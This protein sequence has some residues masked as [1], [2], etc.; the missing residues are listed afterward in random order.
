MKIRWIFDFLFNILIKLC[1]FLMMK[2]RW[3][4]HENLSPSLSGVKVNFVHNEKCWI[5]FSTWLR[6]SRRGTEGEK[7]ENLTPLSTWP[8]RSIYGS[9]S[10]CTRRSP[11]GISRWL[12]KVFS[13]CIW[14][15]I[16]DTWLDRVGYSTASPQGILSVFRGGPRKEILLEMPGNHFRDLNFVSRFNFH[17]EVAW[18]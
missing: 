6:G 13:F 12:L 17:R 10:Q 18:E 2:C 4:Q 14:S 11:S 7:S 16:M 9:V 3:C 8:L 1:L 5:E 15:Q